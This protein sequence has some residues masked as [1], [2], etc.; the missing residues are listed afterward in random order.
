MAARSAT[1]TRWNRRHLALMAIVLAVIG[2]FAV[3][4]FAGAALTTVRL[5]VT[6]DGRYTVSDG[7]CAVLAGIDEPIRLRV[8]RSRQLEELG[9]FFATHAGRVDALLQRYADLADGKLVIE[10][11]DPE[12]FSP[13][14]DLA[15]ADGIQA[16]PVDRTGNLAYFGLAGVN[17]TD[18]R[19]AIGFLA[20]DRADF[21]EY[22]VTRMI[23]DLANPEKTTVAVI[24]D[25]PLRGD[26]LNAFQ[27][28]LITD[29]VEQVFEV[30]E[31]QGSVERID[32]DVDV[33]MLAQPTALDDRTLYAID[34]YVLG[35]GRVLAFVDPF[36][37]VL[38]RQAPGQ[39]TGGDAV[40]ALEP[41]L[42]AWGVEMSGNRVVGDRQ[43]A[44]RVRALQAGLPV[45][46][47]YLPWL[48]LGAANMVADDPVVGDLQV[49]V[50][51]TAG[52]LRSRE[53]A[54]TTLGPLVVTSE[55]AATFPAEPLRLRPDPVALLRSFEP[56][57]Q[58][59]TIAARITGP[60]VSAFPDG[61][62]RADDK[63]DD[64]PAASGQA[65]R[66]EGDNEGADRPAEGAADP[67]P[68][69]PVA[70][71]HLRESRVPAMLIVVADADLL[72]DDSWVRE[73]AL[74]GQRF[75][76][77]A[78]NNADL[79]LNA[80]ES[81]AGG[82]A[83]ASLRGRSIEA[84]RFEVVDAM[85]RRA[86]D[87]YR[88]TE[89][90]LLDRIEEAR[91][92]ISSLED[93]GGEE[94]AIVTAARRQEIQAA[95]QELLDLRQQ[96]RA[97]QFA[98]NEEVNALETRLKLIN[99]VAVPAVVAVVAVGLALWRR[100]RAVRTRSV[101]AASGGAASGGAAS[102][103]AASGGAAP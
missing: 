75:T 83:L 24:G 29:L 100:R 4:I 47:D 80:L 19:E 45:V 97:V 1:T 69:G 90:A 98:L 11:F 13:E 73:N 55:E 30:R 63:D 43:A 40:A 7:T 94:A 38:A 12:P 74:F 53:G 52:A 28:W 101:P 9:P 95:R 96:L 92:R 36:A 81:L 18:D 41:L 5:D 72:A 85:M 99:I 93:P 50:V 88:A 103:G 78:A 87:E 59:L 34:Q 67:D 37:E 60:V 27:P 49:L 46:S 56:V 21:L 76:V 10:R 48:A 2:F 65:P 91:Q 16:L 6:G 51:K 23:A 70:A 3:N 33:L 62:P 26:A 102:G 44:V 22:D 42:T 58:P 84:R 82:S 66:G 77:P 54:T 71:G 61:P 32:D 35:G 68:A 79:V 39:A 86:E 14:E 17:S 64:E 20:P 15:V 57:G 8:Y 25:L 89:Q 31:I